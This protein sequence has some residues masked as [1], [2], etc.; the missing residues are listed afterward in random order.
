M[1]ADGSGH[2]QVSRGDALQTAGPSGEVRWKE[3]L[4][5]KSS[6]NPASLDVYHLK[7]CCANGAAHWRC[8][9]AASLSQAKR[10]LEPGTR[11]ASSAVSQPNGVSRS[12]RRWFRHIETKRY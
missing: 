6:L 2:P 3:L 4:E 1:T 11:D 12:F 9:L 5:S 8:R 7:I 10:E